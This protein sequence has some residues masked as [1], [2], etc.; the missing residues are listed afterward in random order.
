MS[1]YFN[2]VVQTSQKTYEEYEEEYRRWNRLII[3]LSA[4]AIAFVGSMFSSSAGRIPW[5]MTTALILYLWSL[6]FGLTVEYMLLTR[7]EHRLEKLSQ[8]VPGDE[9]SS[10]PND[11]YM[12]I[13][14]SMY[15]SLSHEFP[16]WKLHSQIAAFFLATVLVLLA[17]VLP[18]DPYYSD[19]VEVVLW[20][21]VLYIG[22]VFIGLLLSRIRD[23]SKQTNEKIWSLYAQRTDRT[24]TPK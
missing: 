5:L 6:W 4:G 1:D 3:G 17:F 18:R 16:S 9:G 21:A 23:N 11:E 12:A 19:F 24:K 20:S 2:Y 13:P 8:R 7:L 14:F 10:D 15:Q 22:T